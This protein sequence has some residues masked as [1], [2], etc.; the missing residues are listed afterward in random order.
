[1]SATLLVR[2]VLTSVFPTLKQAFDYSPHKA[3]LVLLSDYATP[4]SAP[5]AQQQDSRGGL[6]W[7]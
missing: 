3:A 6:R 2:D 4:A 1:M 5:P 7:F